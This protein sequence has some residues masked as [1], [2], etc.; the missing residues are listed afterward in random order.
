VK[1]AVPSDPV[2]RNIY[3]PVIKPDPKIGISGGTTSQTPK[4]A[5]RVA[6]VRL[7]S[8]TAEYAEMDSKTL[9]VSGGPEFMIDRCCR[10][11]FD[12]VCQHR[13]VR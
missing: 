4:R 12:F 5:T 2:S 10:K 3:D 7:W 9:L 1:Q 6:C 11:R 8:H 13:S